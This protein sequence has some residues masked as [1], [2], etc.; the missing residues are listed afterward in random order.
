MDLYVRSRAVFPPVSKADMMSAILYTPR[1]LSEIGHLEIVDPY[2]TDEPTEGEVS[3]RPRRQA[4]CTRLINNHAVSLEY[5]DQPLRKFL[6][7][8]GSV[9]PTYERSC[10]GSQS[11]MTPQPRAENWIEASLL[12]FQTLHRVVSVKIE[13]VE[14]LSLHL[15]FD[16]RAKTLKLFKWPSLCLVMHGTTNGTGGRMSALSQ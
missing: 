9:I 16:S 12:C 8:F 13:W 4:S 7:H 6:K 3:R 10:F 14:S 15:E 11:P 5:H 2:T 1:P